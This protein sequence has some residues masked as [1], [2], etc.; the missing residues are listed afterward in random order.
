MHNPRKTSGRGV[1]K[2]FPNPI[3]V[4]V[5]QRIR[6]RRVLLGMTQEKVAAAIGLTYQQ[7]QKY[8]RGADRVVSSRLFVL[9]RILNVKISYFFEEMEASVAAKSPSQLAGV[10]TSKMQTPSG[11]P[12]PLGKRET[13]ELV[14]AYYQIADPRLRK[15]VFEL[16]KALARAV[17]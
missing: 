4:Y 2:G 15:R 12:D 13:L 9:A 1:S 11:E 5:G 8:E 16:A 17:G 14:R 6:Q 3:D 7:V 10:P